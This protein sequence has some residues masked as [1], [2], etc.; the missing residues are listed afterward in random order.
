MAARSRIGMWFKKVEGAARTVRCPEVHVTSTILI[1]EVLT[2][3]CLATLLYLYRYVP[4]HLRY[5]RQVVGILLRTAVRYYKYK[6]YP[7]IY[8]F[9]YLHL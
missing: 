4:T 1:A 9:L 8:L 7:D 6:Y 3:T 2:V 5:L